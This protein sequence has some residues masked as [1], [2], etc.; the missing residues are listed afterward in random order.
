MTII[1]VS[2][3]ANVEGQR[4]EVARKP[5]RG[6]GTGLRLAPARRAGH[7]HSGK[8]GRSTSGGR[9]QAASGVWPGFAVGSARAMD[10]GLGGRGVPRRGGGAPWERGPWKGEK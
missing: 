1:R 6:S 10:G 3:L 4:L 5:H 7:P 8:S 9:S 2:T